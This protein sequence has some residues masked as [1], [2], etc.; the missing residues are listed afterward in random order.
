MKIIDISQELFSCRVYPGDSQPRFER[1]ATIENDGYNL[2]NIALN[3]HNGTHIDAPNHFVAGA[4]S[5]SELDLR[6]F[7]GECTVA[8]F[9]GI[10]EE[11]DMKKILRTC[12]ERLLIKGTAELSERAAAILAESHVKLFGVESQ[13]VGNLHS[14]AP[15]HIALLKKEIIPL[16]GLFLAHVT[17]G[18]YILAAFPL[19]MNG[20]DGSPVRAVLIEQQYTELT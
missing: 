2:T 3:A 8:E 4:K 9:S 20:A 5:V 6:V 11:N 10:I 12:R 14:P 17:P 18:E 13:S 1:V 16:E 19:N 7:F 15:I